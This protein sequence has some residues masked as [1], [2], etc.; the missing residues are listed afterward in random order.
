MVEWI[1]IKSAIDYCKMI[2]VME[3]RLSL[4]LQ[5]QSPE[6]IF[7]LEHEDVYTAGTS[8]KEEELLDKNIKPILVGR[9]GKLTYH[10]KGQ[11]IIYPLLSLEKRSKKDIK[12][13]IT[14]LEE[15]IIR[16]L[17][18]FGIEAYR[19][20]NMIGIWTKDHKRDAKIASIGVRIKKWVTYHGISVNIRTDISKFSSIIPCGLY[21][22][23][24]TSFKELGLNVTIEEFDDILKLKF[25]DLF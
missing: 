1:T 11:R 9:G 23:C 24:Q 8:F 17:A 22:S 3:D 25:L 16:T 19:L 21:N 12:L 4:I 20:P 13:Y 14:T 7:L 10:G 6:T 18:Y 2:Q 15:W 5:N